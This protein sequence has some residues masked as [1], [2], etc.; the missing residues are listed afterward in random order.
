MSD[1]ERGFKEEKWGEGRRGSEEKS[2]RVIREG[3]A[4]RDEKAERNGEME[5]YGEDMCD[6]EGR[7]KAVKKKNGRLRGKGRL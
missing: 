7:E 4:V 5:K 3:K 1:R 6:C 2:R